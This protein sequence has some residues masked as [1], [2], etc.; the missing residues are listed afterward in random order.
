MRAV[1]PARGRAGRDLVRQL[2]AGLAVVLGAAVV[3][4]ALGVAAEV[5]TAVRAAETPPTIVVVGG[6]R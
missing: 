4:V 3:V 1:R 5:V 6:V 2:L